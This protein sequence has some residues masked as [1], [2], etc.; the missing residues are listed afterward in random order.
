MTAQN[1]QRIIGL[2]MHPDIFSAAALLGPNAA[3]AQVLWQHDRI[4]TATLERWACK[5]LQ[6]GDIIVLE[7]SGNSFDVARRLHTCGHCAL[8]LESAQASKI[9]HNFCNDDRQSAVK[10]ARVYLS[11]LAKEV[12]QPDARTRERRDVLFA[13]RSAVKDSTIAREFLT[14]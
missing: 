1:Q 13:H 2:D 12:W 10:L 4:E 8:V 14:S 6:A 5:Y 7:A 3:S 11:G 9:K